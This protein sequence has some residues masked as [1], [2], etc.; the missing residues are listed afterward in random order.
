MPRKKNQAKQNDPDSIKDAGNKAF[1]AKNFE[2]AVKCYTVAIE[3]TLETPNHVYFANRANAQ[4][5]LHHYEECISDCNSAIDIEP[6]YTKSY[7]RKAKALYYQQKLEESMAT[8]DVALGFEPDNQDIMNFRESI[9]K[10]IDLD[11]KL[12]HDHPERK[13]FQ[14]LLGWMKEGG[15]DFSKLKLAFYSE[16]NRG[17]HTLRDIK[18]GEQVL[19]VPDN[20]LIT[21]EM[22][23]QSPLGK[24]MYEKGLRQRLISP[25][26]NFL[27]AYILQETRKEDSLWKYYT[28]LLP[29]DI[30]EFPVFFG[31]D[32]KKWLEGSRFIYSIEEKLEEIQKDYDML[33]EEVPDFKQFDIAEY[34]KIRMIVA[35]RIFGIT[36]NKVKT[37]A[38]VPFADM[39]NHKRPRET[40]WYYSDQLQGFVIEACED[41]E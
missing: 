2:E 23:F 33:C 9:Q 18:I 26:H 11:N 12:P 14:D 1:M 32:D 31:E 3:I 8:I 15:A 6:S 13:R 7:Y 4:L 29:Q 34:K 25:K 30:G 19:F 21:L 37:D 22:A 35:S 20:L 16:N 10:E 40:T 36:I 5:E 24:L 28:D 39:L 41:L 27:G 38:F 17:V